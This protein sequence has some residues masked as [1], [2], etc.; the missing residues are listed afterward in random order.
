MSLH[1]REAFS[2]ICSRGA[3]TPSAAYGRR[4]SPLSYRIPDYGLSFEFMP[5]DFIQVNAELNRALV[6]QAVELLAPDSSDVVWISFVG[7]GTSAWH[8]L[9]GPAKV[10]GVEGCRYAGRA[11]T[12]QRAAQRD[13]ERRVRDGDLAMSR[14]ALTGLGQV[15]RSCCSTPRAAARAKSCDSCAEPYPGRILYV[16]C[17]PATLARDAAD[18]A[19]QHGYRVWP[20]VSSI[21]FPTP[22]M[23]RR[24]RFSSAPQQPDGRPGFGMV[25]AS[26]GRNGV[27]WMPVARTCTWHA[28]RLLDA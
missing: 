22:A 19:A 2:F 4:P 7:S 11:C 21:C 27:A 23:S 17:N 26:Q 6:H 28:H 3:W 8:W 10:L 25:R 18:L 5:S 24:S 14:V 12:S 15:A 20:A 13:C 9:A 1:E 16:S